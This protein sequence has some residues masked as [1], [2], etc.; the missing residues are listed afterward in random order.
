MKH[1][2]P[3]NKIRKNPLGKSAFILGG[4]GVLGAVGLYFVLRPKEAEAADTGLKKKEIERLP[5]QEFEDVPIESVEGEFDPPSGEGN[6][7]DTTNTGGGSTPAGEQVGLDTTPVVQ[8]IIFDKHLTLLDYPDQTKNLGTKTISKPYPELDSPL[9]AVTF[10]RAPMY[11]VGNDTVGIAKTIATRMGSVD[12]EYVPTDDEITML[13]YVLFKERPNTGGRI[14]ELEAQRERAAMLW[15]VVERI[16][17]SGKSI[18]D[19]VSSSNFVGY[20]KDFDDVPAMNT[21]LKDQDFLKSYV[22]A[23]FKGYFPQEAVATTSWVHA[24]WVHVKRWKSWSLPAG[25]K[26]PILVDG[27]PL[28][29]EGKEQK[30]VIENTSTS[31]P[32]YIGEAVFS[33]GIRKRR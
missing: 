8:D 24:G 12:D 21:A 10:K 29:V 11:G 9:L 25:T 15:A 4:L 16:W 23:F 2:K 28:I 13:A 1:V 18:K 20:Y 30:A 27:K 31:T 7:S 22:K 3:K 26:A 17:A 6:T 5:E 33:R 19:T 14:T 32:Y